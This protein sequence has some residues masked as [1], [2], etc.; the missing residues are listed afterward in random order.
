MAR[1]AR[2]SAGAV[3]TG[4]ALVL[5]F[6]ACSR[7]G[8]GGS[9][10]AT[11]ARAPLASTTTAAPGAAAAPARSAACGLDRQTLETAIEA[12]RAAQGAEPS[13]IADLVP[14]FLSKAPDDWQIVKAP[15]GTATLQPTVAGTAAGC[16]AAGR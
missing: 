3:V 16:T 7:S 5:V 2:R 1:R 4:L 11:T 15:D 13:S 14:G 6:S 10:S 12:Y 9:A 8:S